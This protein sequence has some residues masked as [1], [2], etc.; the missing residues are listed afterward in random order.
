MWSVFGMSMAK[1]LVSIFLNYIL[2]L[3]IILITRLLL[4][5][6]FRF[7]CFFFLWV[8]FNSYGT[9]IAIILLLLLLFIFFLSFRTILGGHHLPVL[10]ILCLVTFS[11]KLIHWHWFFQQCR[12]PSI[13]YVVSLVFL[14]PDYYSVVHDFQLTNFGF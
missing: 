3:P 12:V 5:V 10:E 2:L 13:V 4:F 11:V 7:L 9:V 1:M 6:V 8:L 14:S